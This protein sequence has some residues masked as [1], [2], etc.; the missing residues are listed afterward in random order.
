MTAQ[1]YALH[2]KPMKETLLWE[3]LSLHEI[4]SYYP[5][6]RVKPVNPRSRKVRPYFPG[7]V[8]SRVDLEQTNMTMFMRLPGSS[9]IVAF[10]GMPSHI[11]DTLIAAIRRRVGEIDAAGGEL[12]EGL[13]AGDIVTVQD[14]PFKGYEAIF[15]ARLSGDERVRVFLKLLSRG[16]VPV[17]LPS[18]Q[19]QRK[20]H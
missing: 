12:F 19:I 13:K 14:G 15:D 4:E 18:R 17:E 9:G 1:W 16:Q 8:F 10:D 3:Q 20:K 2:S 6:I 7:Y 11:P 5:R